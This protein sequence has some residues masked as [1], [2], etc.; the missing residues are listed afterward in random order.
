MD[1]L[2]DKSSSPP[3]VFTAQLFGN[4]IY[5]WQSWVFLVVTKPPSQSFG[6]SLLHP[7]HVGHQKDAYPRV[8][9]YP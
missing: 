2:E 7:V 5:S 8:T 9:H 3:S 6:T 1:A 4:V